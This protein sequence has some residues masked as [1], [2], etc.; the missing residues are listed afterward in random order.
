MIDDRGY[1]T[2]ATTSNIWIIKDKKLYTSIK[3]KYSGW[4]YE[5]K[6]I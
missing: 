6:S 4:G 5:K 1:I 3:E 2:E